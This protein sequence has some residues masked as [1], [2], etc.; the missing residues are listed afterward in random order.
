MRRAVYGL[1]VVFF[2]LRFD[3]WQMDDPSRLLG[4]P[5]GLGYH[6]LYTAATIGVLA[7]LVR[8]AWPSPLQE[9]Q[10]HPAQGHGAQGQ[11]A[12]GHGTEDAP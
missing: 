11:R 12:Q 6:V 5:V 7:L 3:L 9:A 10:G 8:F 2:L 1:V 4:L